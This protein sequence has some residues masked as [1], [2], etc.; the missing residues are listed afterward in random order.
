MTAKGRLPPDDPLLA[1]GP[2]TAR[3]GRLRCRTHD[4]LL[5]LISWPFYVYMSL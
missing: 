4:T 5:T 2:R 3:P 1:L